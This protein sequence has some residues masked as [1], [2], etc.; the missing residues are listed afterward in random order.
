MN[1]KAKKP[2]FKSTVAQN[3]GPGNA[4][5]VDVT[6]NGGGVNISKYKNKGAPA[7]Q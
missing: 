6:A 2:L 4:N 1:S 5:A 3:P 7:I